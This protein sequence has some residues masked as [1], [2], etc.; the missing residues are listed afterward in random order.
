MTTCPLQNQIADSTAILFRYTL[1]AMRQ[2]LE[3]I[4]LGLIIMVCLTLGLAPFAPPHVW[5]K[6]TMLA[7]GELVRPI[8]RFDLLFH[9]TPWVL[10]LLKLTLGRQRPQ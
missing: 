9:G 4:P 1:T 10:L 7:R 8:D 3:Q 6:L 5:E 2:W